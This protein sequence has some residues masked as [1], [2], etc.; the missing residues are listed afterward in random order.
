MPVYTNAGGGGGL[1]TDLLTATA[2]D[3][4][5]G[6]TAGVKGNDEPVNGTLVLTGDAADSTVLSGKTYYNTD[7]KS[8]RTGTMV[9]RQQ[10]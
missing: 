3:V 2:A 7:A 10:L 1:D 4:L 9:Q 5:K 6:K 8:K